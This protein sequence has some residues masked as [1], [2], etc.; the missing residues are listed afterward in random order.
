MLDRRTY[1]RFSISCPVHFSVNLLGSEFL[2]EHFSSSGTVVD[3]SRNGLLAQVDRLLAVGTVCGLSLVHADGLVRPRA[4]RGRVC[5]TVISDAGW[6][7][8]V[9]FES[10]VAVHLPPAARLGDR[11]RVQT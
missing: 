11:P 7:I 2:V 4:V 1:P 5:R 9:E 8:G 3:I 6:R 10:P